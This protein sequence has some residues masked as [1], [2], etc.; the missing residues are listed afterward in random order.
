MKPAA[1]DTAKQ[2]PYAIWLLGAVAAGVLLAAGVWWMQRPLRIEAVQLRFA[3]LVQTLQFSARVATL[4]RVDIGSTGTARVAQVLVEEGAGVRSGQVLLELESTQELA[5]L[6]QAQAAQ[7]QAGARLAGLRSTG[8]AAAGAAQAQAQAGL[9]AAQAEFARVGQLVDQGFLSPSRMDEARRARDVAQ[10]QLAGSLAST[11]AVAESG[12]ELAQ[13]QA[14]VRVTQ[15]ASE[16]AQARLALTVVRAPTEATVLSRSVEPGQIVQPGRALLVLAL[17]GPVRI[18]AQ[19]DERFLQQLAVTQPATAIADAYPGQR[20]ALQ[21]L[22]IAPLVDAQ[23]GAVEVKLALVGAAPAF[24]RQDMSLSVEV[25]TARRARTLALPVAAVSGT[26]P[27][28]S[29]SV[30]VVVD[31]RVALRPVR[32][33]LRTLDAVE[34]LEGLSDGEVVVLNRDAKDGQRVAVDLVSAQLVPVGAAAGA[35]PGAAAALGN[36]MGR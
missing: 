22:S 12:T 11:Q 23:R 32:L 28:A 26:T 2:R 19:V 29:A 3:P 4:A 25:E 8:R 35:P 24:L 20:F 30:R 16:A 34:V 33:G 21:V 36:S 9:D 17:S 18:V 1:P 7:Q 15:A 5:A 13:A 31:G 10:A 27:G 14:Q 6:A